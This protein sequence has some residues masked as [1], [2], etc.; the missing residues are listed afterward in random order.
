VQRDVRLHA[1]GVHG[2]TQS[3]TR[4]TPPISP[5]PNLRGPLTSPRAKSD[6]VLHAVFNLAVNPNSWAIVSAIDWTPWNMT[7]MP[8]T[9]HEHRGETGGAR[10]RP[11]IAWPIFGRRR[12]YENKRNG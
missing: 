11:P 7:E 1:R 9:P 12:E 6:T 4:S 5:G 2:P 3:E 8:T 10:F